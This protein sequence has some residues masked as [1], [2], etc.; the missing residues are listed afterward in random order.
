MQKIHCLLLLIVYIKNMKQISFTRDAIRDLRSV[1]P[2]VEEQIKAKLKLYAENPEALANNVKAMQG[3][4]FK[5]C[6]RLRVGDWRVIF[7]ESGEVI[8]IQR[9][10]KRGE[11]YRIYR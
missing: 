11:I 7:L 3:R 2:K 4:Q 10:G 5:D 6:L 8:A 1:P 9:I